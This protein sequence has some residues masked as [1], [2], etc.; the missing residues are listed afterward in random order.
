MVLKNRDALFRCDAS[1]ARDRAVKHLRRGWRAAR[2]LRSHCDFVHGGAAGRSSGLRRGGMIGAVVGA[3]TSVAQ[4]AA[5]D[6]F[7]ALSY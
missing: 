5:V 2:D 3:A 1:R 7:A 6:A 4:P